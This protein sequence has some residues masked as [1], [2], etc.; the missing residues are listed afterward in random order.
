MM[1]VEGS[2]AAVSWFATMVALWRWWSSLP[3]RSRKTQAEPWLLRSLWVLAMGLCAVYACA[4]VFIWVYAISG[5]YL[6]Y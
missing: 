5:D 2:V 3:Y 6:I 4:I 1:I